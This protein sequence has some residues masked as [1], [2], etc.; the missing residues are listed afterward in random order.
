MGGPAG[1]H[2]TGSPWSHLQQH[3]Q[4]C[5][6]PAWPPDWLQGPLPVGG[7]ESE[8]L[9]ED[10]VRKLSGGCT[11]CG[12]FGEPLRNGQFALNMTGGSALLPESL[13]VVSAHPATQA[14]FWRT[15]LTF[16][17]INWWS[18]AH[19]PAH[20]RVGLRRVSQA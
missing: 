2:P 15:A 9:V 19:L 13:F 10:P 20:G 7:A 4:S 5:R 11:T 8:D 6:R 18:F 12:V 14:C 17:Q 1:P 16:Q 3:G